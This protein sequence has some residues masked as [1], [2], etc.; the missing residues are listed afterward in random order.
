MAIPRKKPPQ[1]RSSN[2]A[3]SVAHRRRSNRAEPEA[4]ED[5]IDESSAKSFPASD[6]PSWTVITGIGS[7]R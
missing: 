6:P 5:K 1:S 2:P 7:Q 3:S 4:P